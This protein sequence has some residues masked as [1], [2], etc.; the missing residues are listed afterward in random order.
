MA[1]TQREI[2]ANA[3]QTRNDQIKMLLADGYTFIRW[4]GYIVLGKGNTVAE[5]QRDGRAEFTQVEF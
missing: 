1:L 4:T 5:V 2:E 3:Y